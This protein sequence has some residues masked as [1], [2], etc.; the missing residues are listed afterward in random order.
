MLGIGNDLVGG[1]YAAVNRG[2]SLS[3]DGSNDMLTLANSL[4]LGTT[5]FSWS[6]WI[7]SPIDNSSS[8]YIIS[9]RNGNTDNALVFIDSN[10]KIRTQFKGNNTNVFVKVGASSLAPL[11][12]TWINVC[13]SVDRDG[14]GGVYINGTTDTYGVALTSASN[15][16]QTLD[17]S[18]DWSFGSFSPTTWDQGIEMFMTDLAFFNVALSAAEVTAI[19]NNGVP[20]DLLG[21]S[22]SSALTAYWRFNENTGT[23]VADEIGSN[24]LTIDGATWSTNVP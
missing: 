5:D 19:Y 7:N 6:F 15:S 14:N 2:Y 22:Q 13:V 16:S 23:T 12:D 24:D 8:A 17:S 10:K 21:H 11:A 3:F 18:V 20:G 9:K 4:N 1:S